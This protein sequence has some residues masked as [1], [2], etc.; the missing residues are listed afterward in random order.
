MISWLL[1]IVFFVYPRRPPLP[2]LYSVSVFHPELI[3]NPCPPR[4]AGSIFEMAPWL[5]RS[6]CGPFQR[7]HAY[8][9]LH[10][11]RA[12]LHDNSRVAEAKWQAERIICFEVCCGRGD[13][14]WDWG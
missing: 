6:R 1:H 10:L 13:G 8:T 7:S 4:Q 12:L 14:D 2:P 11:A 9:K 3:S 5:C